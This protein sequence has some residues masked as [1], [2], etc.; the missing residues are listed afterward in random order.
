MS[1]RTVGEIDLDKIR[2]KPVTDYYEQA[3]VETLLSRY[4]PLGAKRAIVFRLSWNR[5]LTNLAKLLSPLLVINQAA[6]KTCS[7]TAFFLTRA[8]SSLASRVLNISSSFPISLSYGV[9]PIEL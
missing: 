6:F 4:H 2:V 9:I 7:R 5:T 8:A 3:D 1:K